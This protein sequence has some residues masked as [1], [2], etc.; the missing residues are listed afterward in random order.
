MI[1]YGQKS[2]PVY[3]L[4]LISFPVHLYVGKY[5]KIADVEDA[6]RLFK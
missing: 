3:N 1:V 5:D 2:P 4:S 6:T